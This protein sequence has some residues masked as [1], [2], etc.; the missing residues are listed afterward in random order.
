M[1]TPSFPLSMPSISVSSWLVTPRH[2]ELLAWLRFWPIASISS[3]KRTTGA[4]ARAVSKRE[5]RFASELP[6]NW[7]RMSVRVMLTK[8]APISPARARAM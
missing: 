2:P 6:M 8:E 4:C 5:W 3:R 7:S 1:N